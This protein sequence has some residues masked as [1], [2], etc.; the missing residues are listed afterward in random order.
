MYTTNAPNLVGFIINFVFLAAISL[1]SVYC[2]KFVL[3]M[4]IYIYYNIFIQNKL[5]ALHHACCHGHL[6]TVKMFVEEFQC[7]PHRRAEVSSRLGTV[8]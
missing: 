3:D 6:T 8:H 1:K 4:N 2:N 7:D 5:T